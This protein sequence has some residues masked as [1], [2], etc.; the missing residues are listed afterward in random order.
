[1]PEL[2]DAN[3]SEEK[4]NKQKRVTRARRKA[5]ACEPLNVKFPIPTNILQGAHLL[6]VPNTLFGIR[7][8]KDE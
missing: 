4:V 8:E 3:E 6:E 2:E 1:M 7:L 5:I